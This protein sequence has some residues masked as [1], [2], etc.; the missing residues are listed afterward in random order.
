MASWKWREVRNALSNKG[1]A[2][3]PQTSHEMYRLMV[4][5]KATSIRTMIP[6]SEKKEL[7]SSS[8][9]FNRFQQQLHLQNK[10]LVDLFNCPLSQE[11]YIEILKSQGNLKLKD[12]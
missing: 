9:L 10:K 5:G 4:N 3:L 11:E 12:E 6:F 7:N 2:K 1:F 8:P